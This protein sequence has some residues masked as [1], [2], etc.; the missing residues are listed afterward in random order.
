MKATHT[1]RIGSQNPRPVSPKSTHTSRIGSQNPRPVSPKST[2][3]VADWFSK[4]AS[5]FAQIM[6]FSRLIG[7]LFNVLLSP[8]MNTMH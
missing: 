8:S 4:S 1:S 3:T 7:W 6:A 5:C 2:H